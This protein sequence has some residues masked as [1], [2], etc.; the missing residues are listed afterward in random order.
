VAGTDIVAVDNS[1]GTIVRK[2][3]TVS[4]SDKVFSI[5]VQSGKNYRFFLVENVGTATERIYPFYIGANNLFTIST[6]GTFD[7]GFVSTANGNATPANTPTQLAGSVSSTTIPSG[8]LTNDA[9][10]FKTADLKGTW[11]VF[12]YIAGSNPYW[13]RG[14]FTV[15]ANGNATPS[16]GLNSNGG[17]GQTSSMQLSISSSGVISNLT[18][19]SSTRLYM[20]SN[21]QLIVGSGGDAGEESL[22]ILVK[23]GSGFNQNDLTGT[24]KLNYLLGS[25]S[26]KNWKRADVTI[27]NS[28]L[29]TFANHVSSEGSNT[30]PG[31]VTLSLNSNGIITMPSSSMNYYSAITADKNTM[32]ATWSNGDGTKSIGLF[33]RSGG[34][35]FKNADLVGTWRSNWLAIGATSNIWAHSLLV[36]DANGAANSFGIVANGLNET[37]STSST[38]ITLNSSGLLIRTDT[39]FEGIIS[40]D[41]NLM[42]YTGM[43]GSNL[44]MFQ[45]GILI[46]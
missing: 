22:Y 15:D 39:G 14:T 2:T 11:Y 7:L 30:N 28:G 32:I 35:V 46:R 13:A 43:K 19:P 34:T 24:W 9:Y 1:T 33:V 12:Q 45:L 20:S 36:I 26:Y 18:F 3:A 31:S 44:D 27:N 25:S 21:K 4:G 10:A 38:P 29:M 42:V 6:A 8:I 5:K 16:N 37:N 40:L 17:T 41:K 23:A